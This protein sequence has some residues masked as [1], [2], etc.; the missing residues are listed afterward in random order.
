MGDYN[1]SVRSQEGGWHDR[2]LLRRPL[3][4]VLQKHTSVTL[5][6]Q[7]AGEQTNVRPAGVKLL[8]KTCAE[9]PSQWD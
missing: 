8:N 4:D 6:T 3:A 5:S 2:W 7:Q 9:S 1:I